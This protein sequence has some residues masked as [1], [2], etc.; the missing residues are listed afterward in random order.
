MLELDQGGVD[1]RA[2]IPIAGMTHDAARKDVVG[3]AE[4]CMQGVALIGLGVMTWPRLLA[5]PDTARGDGR[6]VAAG[7]APTGRLWRLSMQT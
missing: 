1:L 6:T 5:A 4:R 7:G 2:N 3:I